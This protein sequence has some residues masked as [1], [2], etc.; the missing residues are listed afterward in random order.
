MCAAVFHSWQTWIPVERI[1]GPV[2][3]VCGEANVEWPSCP[4]ARAADARL[5]ARP[6]A[7]RHLLLA[8]P[9]AGHK[10][11][12]LLPYQPDDGGSA[13]SRGQ[14]DAWPQ[15]LDLLRAS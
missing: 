12:L 13:D 8:Y 10:V 15:L 14:A 3:P 2:F 1:V 5:A 6:G 4:Y 7:Q 9:G 11:G